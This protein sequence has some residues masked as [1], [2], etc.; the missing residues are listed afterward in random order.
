[1]E[2]KLIRISTVKRIPGLVSDINSL[3]KQ[4]SDKATK[5]SQKDA[6]R[7]L[8]QRESFTFG[9]FDGKNLVGMAAIHFKETW[10]RKTGIIE[11]VV[12]DKFSRGQGIGRKLTEAL[13]K[14]AKTRKADC[15][16]LTSNPNNPKRK[17]AIAM[18][19]S[20]GFIKRET[21]CYRLE[22]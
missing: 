8:R 6:E 18:Y 15:V 9:A 5:K 2:F 10:M 13:I 22:L 12:V 7:I 16:E 11:D 21:N 14:E 17:E 19:E 1:M 4:L 3:L 20:M